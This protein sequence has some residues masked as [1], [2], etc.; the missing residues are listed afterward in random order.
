VRQQLL[1]PLKLA[2]AARAQSEA[3][4]FQAMRLDKER[5]DAERREAG[6]RERQ[7]LVRGVG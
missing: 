5:E 7:E 6:R 3:D 2:W 1:T 4:R